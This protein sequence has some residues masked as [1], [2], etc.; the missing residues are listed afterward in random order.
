MKITKI[1]ARLLLAVLVLAGVG[2]T[3]KAANTDWMRD[4]KYGLFVHYLNGFNQFTPSGAAW[5]TSGINSTTGWDY[6][7]GG[8][9]TTWFAQQVSD[10]GAKYVIFTLG[11]NSGFYC[12]P[13][14]TFYNCTSTSAG[15][16]CST[17][18]L[19]SKI[20]DALTIKN[21]KLIVYITSNGPSEAPAIVKSGLYYVDETASNSAFRAR[22]N[23]MIKEWS[24]RWGTKVSGWWIDGCWVNGYTNSVDGKA[25]LDALIAACR[26]GNADANVACN[27]G[28]GIYTGMTDKQD[29]LAGEDIFFSKYPFARFVSYPTINPFQY[30]NP[31]G[32]TIPRFAKFAQWSAT[33][34]T[35]TSGYPQQWHT[36]TYLGNYWGKGAN[37]NRFTK[38]QLI[39][40]IKNVSG[41]GG[42]VSVDVVVNGQ[43]TVAANHYNLFADSDGVKAVAQNGATASTADNTR[44]NL[45]LYKRSW[46]MT[47]TPSGT[48]SNFYE[49]EVANWGLSW[50]LG[51]QYRGVSD[52]PMGFPGTCAVDN[53]AYSFAE[54][55]NEWDWNLLVDFNVQTSFKRVSINFPSAAGDGTGLNYGNRF[56]NHY[57]VFGSNNASTWTV[58]IDRTIA[59]PGTYENTL[60]NMVSYRYLKVKAVTPNGAN[61]TGYQMA[62]ANLEV[63]DY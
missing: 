9:N 10:M 42:A 34:P 21:I 3:S 25:N 28:P 50:P 30:L 44:R 62:I 24:Q 8:F 22:Y 35:S 4:A 60:P 57:A 40:Y 46:M 23:D 48:G 20:S 39:N 14:Q 13:N 6:A 17:T 38:N 53:D 2:A 26:A 55:A 61:Q 47:N 11:Q 15:Q 1:I 36:T 52:V 49:L 56:A 5:D 33:L 27:A 63:Y 12:S 54:P 41:A 31:G 32:S 16:Y 59:A 7:V 51:T 37:Y 29:Y 19:I 58:L 43:G 18:D 45:A